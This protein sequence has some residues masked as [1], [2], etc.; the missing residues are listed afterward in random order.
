MAL[1]VIGISIG[2]IFRVDKKYVEDNMTNLHSTCRPNVGIL[3]VL[4]GYTI[5]IGNEIGL[6]DF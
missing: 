2:G 4:R 1:N 5:R 3:V 6:G